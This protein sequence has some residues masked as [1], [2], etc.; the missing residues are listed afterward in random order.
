MLG[1]KVIIRTE[2]AGVHYGTLQI[3][4]G[5]EC[6]LSNARRLW[7]WQG[8]ASLSQLSV[9][10]PKDP[11][12]CKFSVRVEQILLLEAIEIIPVTDRAEK[13]IEGVNEWKK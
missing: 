1:K 4:D 13:V 7:Y 5:R 11:D 12:A 9:D 10:G 2:S 8:A 3:R 6:V